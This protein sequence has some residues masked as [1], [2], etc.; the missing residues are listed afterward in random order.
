[1]IVAF[2]T[3]G[4]PGVVLSETIVRTSAE[5]TELGPDGDASAWSSVCNPRCGGASILTFSNIWPVGCTA[6]CECTGA[7]D[8][9]AVL[10]ASGAVDTRDADVGVAIME[11]FVDETCKAAST[12]TGIDD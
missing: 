10:T 5:I 3:V 6:G 1:M 8:D 9:G 11:L 2:V 4:T 12:G 7:D